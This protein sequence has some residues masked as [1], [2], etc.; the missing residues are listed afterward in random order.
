MRNESCPNKNGSQ[1]PRSKS[2]SKRSSNAYGPTSKLFSFHLK[3]TTIGAAAALILNS[4][5]E[6]LG[7]SKP[8]RASQ[9]LDTKK[10]DFYF[11]LSSDQTAGQSQAFDRDLFILPL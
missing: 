9:R 1:P 2:H 10:R 6:K 4:R 3:V 5:S 7:R 8:L 11:Q